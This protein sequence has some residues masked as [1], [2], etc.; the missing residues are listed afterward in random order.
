MYPS[1]ITSLSRHTKA[2]VICFSYGSRKHVNKGLRVL[3][4]YAELI[5]LLVT[6][7]PTGISVPILDLYWLILF[8]P[9]HPDPVVIAAALHILINVFRDVHLMSDTIGNAY[10]VLFWTERC[11]TAVEQAALILSQYL[12]RVTEHTIRHVRAMASWDHIRTSQP[13]LATFLNFL[14]KSCIR[15]QSDAKGL[16]AV[17]IE[18]IPAVSS[19]ISSRLLYRIA[20]M[21]MELV[22][23]L[24]RPT[25]TKWFCFQGQ[26]SIIFFTF[27]LESLGRRG[28]IYY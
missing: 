6:L 13:L 22:P 16:P 25:K 2:D 10:C 18:F 7:Q 9:R 23:W 21:R 11:C 26:T 28:E 1:I 19:L 3:Q 12:R 4:C 27:P 8:L 20:V 24:I 17:E 15:I 14:I 5:D